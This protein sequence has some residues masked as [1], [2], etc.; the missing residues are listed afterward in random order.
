MREPDCSMQRTKVQTSLHICISDQHLHY[1]LSQKYTVIA[2]PATYK[3]LTFLLL[4]VAEQTES[5]L[6]SSET[7]ILA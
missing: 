7:C 1:S 2:K 4:Y 3:I 6:A 5:I